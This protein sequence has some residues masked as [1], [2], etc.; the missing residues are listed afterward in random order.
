MAKPEKQPDGTWAIRA[1]WRDASGKNRSKRRGG[2]IRLRDAIDW[3]DAYV[4]EQKAALPDRK[5]RRVTLS[6]YLD[7]W[8]SQKGPSLSPNTASGYEENIR[9]IKEHP[10]GDTSL[11]RVNRE[12][13]Q[14]FFDSLPGKPRTVLYVY[15]TLHAALRSAEENGLIPDNPARRVSL[16]HE[17]PYEPAVLSQKEAADL[18]SAL[19]REK[20][21]LYIPVLLSLL[22]GLHRGEALGLRWED[23][24]ADTGLAVIRMSYTTEGTR[25][26][27]LRAV[28][29]PGG[30][31]QIRFSQGVLR[32]LLSYRGVFE[33]RRGR[34][35]LFVS[36]TPKGLPEPRSMVKRLNGFQRKHGLKVCRYEDLRRTW[37]SLGGGAETELSAPAVRSLFPE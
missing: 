32:E 20:N 34:F 1:W 31:R 16:P 22:Y 5:S 23:V 15:R 35:P 8:L 21:D 2:F 13:I 11:L 25:G 24:D 3:A 7:T 33:N 28:K 37:E 9:K 36:E 18:L 19:R 17:E 6:E 30:F 14:S 10:L 27:V 12:E 29:T 4:L 26:T